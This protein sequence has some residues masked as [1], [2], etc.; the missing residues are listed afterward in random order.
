MDY[1]YKI[2][3]HHGMCIA[4][5]QGKGY[6]KEFT[7]HMS[8]IIKKLQNAMVCVS[9][10]TDEIC[11]K[12]PNNMHGICKTE[13]KVISYDKKVLDSCDLTDGEILTYKEFYNTVYERIISAGKREKICGDCQWNEIC[14]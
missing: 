14:K 10:Q 6:S 11:R 3:P 4:F 8:E 1:Q 12:C 5:F 7:T 9:I 13:D 2:R